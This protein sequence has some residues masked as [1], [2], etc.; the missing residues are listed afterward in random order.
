M[1][2]PISALACLSGSSIQKKQRILK[3]LGMQKQHEPLCK[4]VLI[5]TFQHDKGG[6]TRRCIPI[7]A[8]PQQPLLIQAPGTTLNI[9]CIGLLDGASRFLLLVVDI[10]HEESKSYTYN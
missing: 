1:N 9:T 8:A 2:G 6:R 10:L 3:S 5:P 4:V 7:S